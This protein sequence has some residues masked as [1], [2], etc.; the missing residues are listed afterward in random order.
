MFNAAKDLFTSKAARTY[1]NNV[2]ARYGRV[3]EL[4]IDSRNRKLRVV[5]MLEGEVDAVTLDVDSYQV[6]TEGTKK[7][8]SIES[9]RC[10]RRWVETLLKDKVVGRRF[11]LPPWA[12]AAL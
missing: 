9:C 2:I 11:E 1:A 4:E 10:S 8:I 3:E 5:A 7:F 6:H 12:A